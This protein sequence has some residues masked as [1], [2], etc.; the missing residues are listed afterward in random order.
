MRAFFL[1]LLL[2]TPLS[3]AELSQSNI[4]QQR[5]VIGLSPYLERTVKDDVYRSIVRLLVE[6]LPLGSTVSVYDAYEL[7]SITQIALPNAKLFNSS[8]ARANQFAPAIREVKQFL[9]QDHSKPTSAHLDLKGAIRLPQFCDFIVENQAGSSSSAI[10]LLIMGS[11]LYQD[12]KEPTFSMVNGYFPSDGHLQTTREKSVFGFSGETNAAPPLLVHWVYFGDPWISDL[13]REQITRFWSL[14]LDHRGDQLATFCADLATC[15]E[16]YRRG[17]AFNGSSLNHWAIDPQQTKIEMLRI[18]RTMQSHD[19][20]T[21]DN[22]PDISP[23]AP[24]TMIGP[25][26]IGIRWKDN[27]DLDL[28]A[29]PHR[30]AETLF[31]QHPQSPEGYYYKDHRSSPGRE[32]EFIEFESPVD[33]REVEASVNFYKGVCSDGPTGEIRIEFD[34]KIYSARFSIIASEGNKGRSGHSQTDYW[35][36]IPIQ[37]MLKISSQI[38]RVR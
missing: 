27:I 12:V 5:F 30:G 29:T 2:A 25:L 19:W 4:S 8:K 28:Y 31:F 10:S 13:H 18:N 16:H 9:A 11:P 38:S 17:N 33:I 26:K 36:P 6:D 22:L 37:E 15:L 14:Y 24:D 34:G 7:K 3:A 20:L 21:R 32:F 35:T 1:V 23:R